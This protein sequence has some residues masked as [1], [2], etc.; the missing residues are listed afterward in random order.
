MMP[1]VTVPVQESAAE[2]NGATVDQ[3]A[4]GWFLYFLFHFGKN[5]PR[6]NSVE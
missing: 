4:I 3:D 1:K 5:V 6:G 2:M